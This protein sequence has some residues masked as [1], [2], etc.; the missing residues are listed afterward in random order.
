MFK[1]EIKTGG[2]AFCNPDTGN[3]DE[4]WEGIEINKILS[5]IQEQIEEGYTSGVV[6]DI[7]G[8][9]CGKWSR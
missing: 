1:L 8:N 3:E 9:R 6:I 5:K 4:F 2:A 7:N